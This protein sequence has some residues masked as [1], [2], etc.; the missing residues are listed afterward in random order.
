MA[1]I[2]SQDDSHVQAIT[3][4]TDLCLELTLGCSGVW[5]HYLFLSSW[6]G[7]YP[8]QYLSVLWSC[9]WETEW[10]VCRPLVDQD[11]WCVVQLACTPQVA[12]VTHHGRVHVV[13]VSQQTL[14]MQALLPVEHGSCQA[15]M[16]QEF[17]QFISVVGIRL[18]FCVF[19]LPL[20]FMCIL[21]TSRHTWWLSICMLGVV[22]S[23]VQT[24]YCAP[25]LGCMKL[26]P[27]WFVRKITLLRL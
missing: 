14:L 25:T 9:D 3:V 21:K 23:F 2:V 19:G 1:R 20:S 4:A 8:L 27:V 24:L 17:G 5:P 16:R 15:S 26:I 22:T 12:K 10:V 6:C 11:K 7:P 18:T 13:E